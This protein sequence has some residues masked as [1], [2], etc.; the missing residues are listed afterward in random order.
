[1]LFMVVEHFRNRNPQPIHRSFRELGRLAPDGLTYVASWVDDR[2]ERCFQL[3]ATDD[4]QLLDRWIEKWS[5][6]VEFEIY[7]V[8]TSKDAAD[9]IAP[10]LSLPTRTRPAAESAQ[11][12]C[13]PSTIG[14]SS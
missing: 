11:L 14:E 5:D 8:R 2:S 1:M 3:M 4:H 9:H 12:I 7:P 13:E 6:L 10:R